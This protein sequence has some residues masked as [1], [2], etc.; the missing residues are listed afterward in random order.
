V[1]EGEE[2]AMVGEESVTECE[3]A[4]EHSEEPVTQ[5]EEPVSHV[6]LDDVA[7]PTEPSVDRESPEADQPGQSVLDRVWSDGPAEHGDPE[8]IG[9]PP[10]QTTLSEFE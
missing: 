5:D 9:Q 2:T 3:E 4:R 10:D 8:P 6:E 1:T 7:I